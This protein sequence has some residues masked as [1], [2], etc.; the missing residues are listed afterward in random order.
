MLASLLAGAPARGE[1]LR[2]GI[3]TDRDTDAKDVVAKALQNKGL[4]AKFQG[5]GQEK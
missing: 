3:F 4:Q 1:D 5:M 2:V